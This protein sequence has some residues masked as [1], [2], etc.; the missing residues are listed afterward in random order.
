[1]ILYNSKLHLSQGKLKSRWNE[2]FTIH[3]VYLNGTVNLLNSKDNRVLKVNGQRMK[4]YAIH[5]TVD[6]EEIPLIDPP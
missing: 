4:P 3:Q 5:H 6:K 2:S 1:M